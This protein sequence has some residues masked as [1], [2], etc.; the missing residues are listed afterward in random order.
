MTTCAVMKNADPSSLPLDHIDMSQPDLYESDLALPFFK[1]L[2]QESPVHYCQ[3]AQFEP[4]WS[5]TKFTDIVEIEKDYKH[6]SNSPSIALF[7]PMEEVPFQSFMQMDPPKH[8]SQRAAVQG[9]V[10]PQNLALLEPVI[11]GKAAKILDDLPLGESFDWVDRVSI[12]LTAQMLATIMGVPFED[13]RKLVY[14]SDLTADSNGGGQNAVRQEQ[15]AGLQECAT[16]FAGLWNE[17][18]KDPSGNDLLCMLINSESTKNLLNDNPMEFLGNI[19]LLIV[20]GN[21]TTR[22]SISGGVHALNQFPAE[23]EK[24][25]NNPALIPN[26]VSE[27]IRWQTPIIYMR[28]RATCDIEFRGQTIRK[29]DKVLLW[30]LSG[31]R[32]EE[33]ISDADQ[34]IIDRAKA[35][36]HLSFGFGLHRCMGNRLAELQLRIVWEEI[37]KRFRFVEVVSE[38][39]RYR[40]AMV[41]GFTAMEVQVHPW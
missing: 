11:R 36:H 39:S 32:D 40:S 20:G 7:D 34:F 35:R 6:F 25:R 29:D 15:V 12:E 28:R 21:D 19:L 13:R 33:V 27:I 14:W 37:M 10:A 17:K 5:I 26:M 30:Y 31:N 38:P 18:V 9:V 22:N 1:R 3:N 41:R 2:R 23:Y 24:L 16:Y 8:D 4:F